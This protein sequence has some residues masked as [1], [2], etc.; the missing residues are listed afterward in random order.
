VAIATGNAG[1]AAAGPAA[2]AIA[3]LLFSRGK[4]IRLPTG[5]LFRMKFDKDLI[6][7]ASVTAGERAR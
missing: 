5:T 6:L 4:D 1:A 2:G 7:P 3:G